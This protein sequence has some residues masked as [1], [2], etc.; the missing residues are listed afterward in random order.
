MIRA[1]VFSIL[2]FAA[3]CEPVYEPIMR[4][5]VEG[6]TGGDNCGTAFFINENTMLT[7]AHLIESSTNGE[8]T[9]ISEGINPRTKNVYMGFSGQDV[10]VIQ[11]QEA[12]VDDYLDVCDITAIGVY[13]ELGGRLSRFDG[14][15][16][17]HGFVTAV[18]NDWITVDEEVR[19]GYSG[20]PA[21]DL[22]Q[23]CAVGVISQAGGGVTVS[24]NLIELID[25]IEGV[26]R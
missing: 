25:E 3:A 10:A 20:G 2:V 21:Y 22:G 17:K 11:M 8:V 13:I 7:S 18:D 12:Q 4:I 14:V 15:S 16:W 23:E 9:V 24:T 19:T 1:I 5:C 6:I 26:L